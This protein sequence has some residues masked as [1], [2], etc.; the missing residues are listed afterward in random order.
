MRFSKFWLDPVTFTRAQKMV[1]GYFHKILLGKPGERFFNCWGEE[2]VLK[3]MSNNNF[4]TTEQI[5]TI[6][7][8]NMRFIAMSG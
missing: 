7:S 2:L 1:R 4:A 6:F 5:F 3:Q 8:G